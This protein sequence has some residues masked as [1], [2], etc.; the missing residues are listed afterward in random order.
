MEKVS[1]YRCREYD[2]EKIAEALRRIIDDSGGLDRLFAKGKRVL[3]KP[4]LV[5][6]KPPEHAATTHPAVIE[7][8]I[9]ILQTRTDDITITECPGGLNNPVQ[10]Q[11][12]FRTTGY[13]ALAKNYGVKLNYEMDVV[14]KS[15]PEPISSA[16]FEC[17][18]IYDRADVLIN[19]AKL[20]THSLTFQ[21]GAAKNLYGVIPGLKKI[22]Y[23]AR[24][25]DVEAFSGFIVDINRAVVPDLNIIDGI[26]AMEGNGPT[27]G[28]AR[29][30]GVLIG[31]T[32]TFAVDCEACRVMGIPRERAGILRQAEK[33]GRIPAYEALG[34]LDAVIGDLILPDS[35]RET[36]LN[37]MPSLF[38]GRLRRLI[39]PHPRIAAHLCVGCGE[40]VRCCPQRTIVME[41]RRKK[42]KA[43]INKSGCILCYCCQELCPTQ[44]VK[45]KRKFLFR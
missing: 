26:L 30:A 18:R 1:V 43:R 10:M 24:F 12:N 6:R 34:D 8:L 20:K 25:P 35:K 37:R 19:V 4:N 9:R 13:T 15:C 33:H 23:H 29:R 42:P 36:L 11:A 7:A 38:G 21:S 44:A 28:T 39:E 31:G 32:N 2:V 27:A 40:C 41:T 3:I 14:L 22:E 45:I 16:N 17:Q 5:I